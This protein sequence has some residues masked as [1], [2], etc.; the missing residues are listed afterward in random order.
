MDGHQFVYEGN[1]FEGC[2]HG[3]G[4]DQG[5]YQTAGEDEKE[6]FLDGMFHFGQKTGYTIEFKDNK[7]VYREK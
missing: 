6:L 7:F 5:I 2:K 4:T 3:H 1:F